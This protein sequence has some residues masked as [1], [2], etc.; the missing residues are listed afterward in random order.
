MQNRDSLA[1]HRNQND[2]FDFAKIVCLKA[3]FNQISQD[4]LNLKTD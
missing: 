2:F 4:W 1:N 3:V